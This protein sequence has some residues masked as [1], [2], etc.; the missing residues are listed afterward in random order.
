MNVR[1]AAAI[2][3]PEQQF[4]RANWLIL[5]LA[6]ALVVAS[7]AQLLYRVA[8]PTDGWQIETSPSDDLVLFDNVLGAVSPLQPGDVIVAIG[9]K[10]P[11]IDDPDLLTFQ[12]RLPVGWQA[13]ALVDYQVRRNGELIT[14]A[15]P[16][17]RWR[18]APLLRNLLPDPLL[19]ATLL[20]SALAGFAFLRRPGSWG[21]RALFI[22]AASLLANMISGAVALTY[23]MLLPSVPLNTF[24]SFIS[25]AI[26]IWP[27]FFLLGLSFPRPKKLLA[28][29]P[30]I[31]LA[32]IYG[33]APLAM[34]L[35]GDLGTG[36]GL[37]VIWALLTVL[38][39]VHSG[40]TVRDPV[41]RAQL[42]WA[43]AGVT[44][45][46][47]AMVVNNVVSIAIANGSLHVSGSSSDLIATL[48]VT[49]SLLAPAVGFAIAILRYR[50]FDIDVI[51]RRTLIYSTLTALLAL[52]YF[53]SVI[54]LQGVF[55]AITGQSESPAVVILSTLAIAAL[56]TPV[57]IRVQSF[58]DRRFFR[59]KYDSARILSATSGVLRDE[60][61]LD[62]IV[63]HLTTVVQDTLQPES[64]GFWIRARTH[65]APS[66]PPGR[67]E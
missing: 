21:A 30:A 56:F 44:I 39:V 28:A 4:S 9:G 33:A 3:D 54:L 37:V 35:T 13:G 45:G 59:R 64:V 32:A 67:A 62:R 10:S 1:P 46:G 2:S 34:L 50:L 49:I 65:T 48:P 42:R 31:T 7:T 61:E 66:P 57:R 29:H 8:L 43:A 38:A 22:L 16:L 23:D 36:W 11:A 63:D 53:G 6:L 27:S 17:Y 14:M 52:V 40:L 15:V 18:A 5:W 55:R 12:S 26:L 25:W 58:I 20:M 19:L 60:V 47:I 41:G 24:F 51:I